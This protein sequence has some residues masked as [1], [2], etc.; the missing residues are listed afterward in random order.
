MNQSSDSRTGGFLR[1]EIDDG[2]AV[3][4]ID[5]RSAQHN[6]IGISFGE[7]LAGLVERVE[8]DAAIRAVVLRSGKP[9][10]FIVGAN[11][12][13][14][15]T[16]TT[17]DDAS[18]LSAG[19]AE[20]LRRVDRCPKPFV[21]A[22]HGSALGGGF[23][24]AL[25]CRAI[26]LSDDKK[27][28]LGLPEV[29]LGVIPGGNG[30]LRVARRAGLETALDLGLTGK[31]V[32]PAKARALGLADEV[33]PRAILETVAK[34]VARK[35]ANGETLAKRK[36]KL[37]QA[38]ARVVL[39]DTP[40]GRALVFKKARE[41]TRKK[42]RG[43]YPATERIIDVLEAYAKEGEA[44]AAA[45]EAKAF[46]EV[47]VSETAHRLM[48]IFH[49]QTALK[50]DRGTD[51]ANAK[52]AD[53]NRVTVLGGGLMGAGIS[54]VTMQAGIP[55]RLKERDDASAGRALKAVRDLLDQRVR[56]RAMSREERDQVFARL[57]TTTDW[58]GIARTDIVIEAVFEDLALKQAIVRD[59]EAHAPARAIF[60]S[61]TSSIPIGRIAEASKRP[62]RIVGMHY[63]S[64]VNKMPLLEV[65]RTERTAADVVATAVALG[66]KQG[67]TVIVVKDGVGFYTSRILGPYMNEA[68]FL[69]AEGV[70]VD[71][72]DDAL[73]DWGFPVGPL[74]LLDEVGIDVAAHVGPIMLEAFGARMTPPATMAALIGDDRKGRK[75]GRGFYVYGGA[76]RGR[77]PLL[78]FG[79]ARK[80]KQVDETV[81]AT[82]GVTPKRTGG[83][84]VDEIQLRCALQMINE[85]LHCLGEGI[86]RSPRD[87]D[88]GA[89]FGLGYPPFRGG[90]FRTVDAMEAKDVLARVRSFEDRFGPRFAPAP[91]LV[92][93]AKSG[94]RLYPNG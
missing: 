44:A 14:L 92:D 83:P 76:K 20:I 45:V 2:I 57:S 28:V 90:P 58:T 25:A 40:V 13:M 69:V 84:A 54:F 5:D 24:V 86:L 78:R 31:N 72:V 88:I 18:Q 42:T 6:T 62:E 48:G 80:K 38:A 16:V 32:R 68:A 3:V 66:K 71:V 63:F 87:G 36:P 70:P 74:T 75:N 46:G 43:H 47:V 91:L 77:L 17:A 82:L 53:V 34:D 26:V 21:A 35:L 37:A 52:A 93:L 4:T 55:V 65:I 39:E 11:I 33:C 12:D 23:E 9:D 51:D 22:V 61:N 27:T 81:Y 64:P 59:V 1:V 50:K 15:G 7:D 67:K 60:A 85:A 89:I 73:V 49:A 79:G 56:R 30:L 94:R 41:A 10:S 8:R 29:Q 19:M